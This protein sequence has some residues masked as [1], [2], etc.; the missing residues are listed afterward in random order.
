MRVE[1]PG[2]ECLGPAT[3]SRCAPLLVLPL[4]PSAFPLSFWP[5]MD[6]SPRNTAK[7]TQA[8]FGVLWTQSRSAL[9][10]RASF[11]VLGP[12]AS[13]SST[14]TQNRACFASHLTRNGHE[15][16]M[17]REIDP[18]KTNRFCAKKSTFTSRAIRSARFL[19]NSPAPS[20]SPRSSNVDPQNNPA[21]SAKTWFLPAIPDDFAKENVALSQLGCL[22][23]SS[24]SE[25]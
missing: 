6:G 11:F 21:P 13:T 8:H 23:V 24:V 22:D 15:I 20:P 5:S 17:S 1:R 14:L 19:S 4:P 9:S 16:S 2:D 10:P 12:P 3:R 18:R 7:A 25:P